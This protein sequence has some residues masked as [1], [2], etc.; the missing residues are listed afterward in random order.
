[1]SETPKHKNKFGE[2]VHYVLGMPRSIYVNFRCLPFRQAIRLPILVSHRTRCKSLRGKIVITGPL[3][4]GLVKIGLGTSQVVDFRRER[5][6]INL[7]GKVIF[8][9]KCKIGAGSRIFVAESGTLSFGNNFHNSSNLNIL[10]F[11]TVTFGSNNGQGW[12]NTI[13]DS[14]QHA[15][16]NEEGKRINEDAPI[17]FGNNVWC[18]C[19]CTILKGTTIGNDVVVGANS[20]VSGIHPEN[21]V[22]LAGNPAKVVKSGVR[23]E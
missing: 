9:G 19:H 22:I 18:G 14:D 16:I 3:K 1:M 17:V 7:R 6:I 21:N 13:M 4:V 11:N 12:H 10:C 15:I 23:W 5:T 8:G 2:F 20:N